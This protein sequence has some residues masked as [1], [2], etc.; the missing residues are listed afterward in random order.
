[1]KHEPIPYRVLLEMLEAGRLSPD[2]FLEL[3]MAMWGT[4]GTGR[5]K[6]SDK[7][8]EIFWLLE[9]NDESPDPEQITR[10]WRSE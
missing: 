2:A 5:G 7:L 8:H 10:I 4:V 6:E 9:E 3:F 1:M